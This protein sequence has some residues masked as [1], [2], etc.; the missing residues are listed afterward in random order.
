MNAAVMLCAGRATRMRGA[1]ADKVLAPLEGRAVLE[2]SVRAFL[3]SGVVGYFVFVI[4]DEEQKAAV[5]H[6]L[7][8]MGV[9]AKK[10]LFTVGGEERQDSVFNGLQKVPTD[11]GHVFI[12]DCAR[13][14]ITP[15][16]LRALQAAVK[17]DRAAALAHRVT[18]TIKQV[19]PRAGKKLARLKLR[20]LQ[21]ETLW[22]METPQ[23]FAREL[24]T[25]AYQKIR[26]KKSRITDDVAAVAAL[27]HGVTIVENPAPNPKLTHPEDFAWVELLLKSR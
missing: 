11:A 15:R 9:P 12:H 23:V 3:D 5:S 22:A 25:R 4:R 8:K 6:V 26:A 18:D 7:E 2:Y 17:K 21:R 13:P 19:P 10:I 14:L 16:N 27:G 24:I 20:D 1:V